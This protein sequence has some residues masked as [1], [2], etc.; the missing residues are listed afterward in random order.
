[1]IIVD[2]SVLATVVGDDAAD[3]RRARRELRAA[4]DVSAPDLV[5]VETVAVLRTK[6]FLMLT[7]C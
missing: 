5:D 4:I 1:M 2:A 3:G 6:I 7:D